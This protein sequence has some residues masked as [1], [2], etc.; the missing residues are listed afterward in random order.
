MAIS[1][2][3][4]IQQAYDEGRAHTQRFFKN[5]STAFGDL[6]WIDW[7]FAS[8]QPAYD[9]RIG[10]GLAFN[11]FVATKNDA[12][13]FPDIPAEQSRHLVGINMNTPGG[14]T[15]QIICG[16][17]LYDLIG[18]YPLIDGDSTDEQSLDNT[19][20]LPRYA[21]GEGVQAVLVNHVAPIVSAADGVMTYTNSDGQNKSVAI[22]AALTGQNKAVTAIPTTGA[23][24]A[25]NVPLASGC[26][27][28]RSVNSI[29]WTAAPGGLFA[30]YLIK[31]LTTINNNDGNAVTQKVW[32]EKCLC[33]NNAWQCPRIYDGAHLGF[34]VMT[35]GSA[36]TFGVFGNLNFVWG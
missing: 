1:S 3:K 10:T 4:D 19:L 9:A 22:R 35:N 25:L 16:L 14:S 12:I 33:L 6:H 26:K 34:F 36:R 18:V 32:T 7:A 2:L 23:L 11:P 20:T 17:M 21:S 31:P 24:G 28:V 27:G 5:Q 13:Y 30:I 29:T 8:G 15:G